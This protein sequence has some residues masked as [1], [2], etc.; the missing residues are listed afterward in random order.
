MLSVCIC[1][2]SGCLQ[3]THQLFVNAIFPRSKEAVT[4]DTKLFQAGELGKVP[5]AGYVQHSSLLQAALLIIVC[6]N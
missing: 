6:L 1:S 2:K 5:H 4:G 3:I